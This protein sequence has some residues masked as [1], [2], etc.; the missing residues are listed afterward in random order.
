MS[1]VQTVEYEIKQDWFIDSL[2]EYEPDIITL[3]GHIGLRFSEFYILIDS[4]RK[5]YPTIP[6]AILGGHT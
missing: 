3:I 5:I 1:I 2:T 6:I 4:I